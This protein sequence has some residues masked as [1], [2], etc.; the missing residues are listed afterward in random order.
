[1]HFII[2]N[3]V[4]EGTELLLQLTSNYQG[5][6]TNK[7]KYQNTYR[8]PLDNRLSRVAEECE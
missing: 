6:N 2:N 5:K 1:M 3:S 8:P 4:G 7:F